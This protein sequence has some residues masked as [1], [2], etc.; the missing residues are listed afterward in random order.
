[1]YFWRGGFARR[2]GFC[3][4]VL[5]KREYCMDMDIYKLRR[6]LAR[7][8][9][10]LVENVGRELYSRGKGIKGADIYTEMGGAI[11]DTMMRLL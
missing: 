3:V 4:V 8:M 9:C 5:C 2:E 11:L 7:E 6:K 1:L 10:S